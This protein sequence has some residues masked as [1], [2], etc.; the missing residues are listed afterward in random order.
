MTTITYRGREYDPRT[1]K[2]NLLEKAIADHANQLNEMT[3]R[4]NRHGWQ[5]GRQAYED[6]RKHLYRQLTTLREEKQRRLMLAPWKIALI[7]LAEEHYPRI[8]AEVSDLVNCQ[9]L[10]LIDF[11]THEGRHNRYDDAWEIVRCGRWERPQHSEEPFLVLSQQM[12]GEA[13]QVHI[14]PYHKEQTCSC[15]DWQQRTEE[16][17]GYCK[18]VFAG[19]IL[20]CAYAIYAELNPIEEGQAA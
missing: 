17:G 6:S 4:F 15:W 3:T 14:P 19:L 20:Y 8:T 12:T 7:N 16:H 18:H 2:D 5:E 1:M 11:T 9:G 10:L 13:Y